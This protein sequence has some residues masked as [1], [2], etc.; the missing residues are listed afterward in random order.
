MAA[1][2]CGPSEPAA[3]GLRRG[4]AGYPPAAILPAADGGAGSAAG[5][6]SGAG[7]RPGGLASRM[8]RRVSRT[9]TA[10][11][12]SV[13]PGRTAAVS[14]PA[15]PGGRPLP[16]DGAVLSGQCPNPPGPGVGHFCTGGP[17]D[18]KKFTFMLPYLVGMWYTTPKLEDYP[19]KNGRRKHMR[20]PYCGFR[21]SKV[22]DSRP[23][24]EEQQH[25]P[26][27]GVPVLR[28]AFHHLRDGGEPAHGGHQEGRQP[29][30]L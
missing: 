14:G 22:V 23:A 1:L 27:A 25:S 29:P 5:R 11:G 26:Q 8:G 13:P 16:A 4:R 6:G 30:E 7:I 3:A 18:I 17:G 9:G 2:R 28:E 24:D 12:C 15:L 19:L 21:E 10:G 20:C